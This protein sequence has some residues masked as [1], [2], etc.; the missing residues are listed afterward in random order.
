M[1]RKLLRIDSDAKDFEIAITL[2]ATICFLLA[3]R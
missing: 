1:T 2:V 3:C